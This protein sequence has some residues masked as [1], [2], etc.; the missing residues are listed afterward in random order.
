MI[1]PASPAE[2]LAARTGCKP[3]SSNRPAVW[4]CLLREKR[5]RLGLRLVQVAEAC[6]VSVPA[7]SQIERGS[8]PLLTSARRIASFF[9]VPVEELWPAEKRKGAR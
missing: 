6:G 4:N 7:L 9:G 3:P 5:R 8:D 2:K 1:S